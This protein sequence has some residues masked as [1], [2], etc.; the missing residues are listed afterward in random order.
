MKYRIIATEE[1]GKTARMFDRLGIKYKYV[2]CECCRDKFK[3]DNIIC[4]KCHKEHGSNIARKHALQEKGVAVFDDDYGNLVYGGYA[5]SGIKAITY[6][7]AQL[8]EEVLEAMKEIEDSNEKIIIG[9]YSAGALHGTDNRFC[10]NIMQIFFDGKIEKFFRDESDLYRLND[11]VCACI[12]A[13]KQGYLSV[14][15]W[16]FMRAVQTPELVDNTNN[17]DSKSFAK[18]FLPILYAPTAAKVGWVKEYRLSS[19][20]IRPGRYHHL[21]QWSKIM[22]KIVE[23]QNED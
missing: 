21:I 5:G 1:G 18:S 13:Y 4:Y 15:C 7:D 9:G 14:G 3:C 12:R 19:G 16:S 22:P 2:I 17:Y 20:E 6:K 8:V 23:A 11:D 10:K